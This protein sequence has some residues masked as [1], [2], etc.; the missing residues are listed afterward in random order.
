MLKR[1]IF[2]HNARFYAY[3][4]WFLGGL[5]EFYAMLYAKMFHGYDKMKHFE[6]LALPKNDLHAWHSP[7]KFNSA[8]A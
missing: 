7:N 4:R 2:I 8:F 6:T 3:L 1:G 5:L